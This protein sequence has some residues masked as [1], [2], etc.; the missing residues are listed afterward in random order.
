VFIIEHVIYIVCVWTLGNG[1]RLCV[2]L[3]IVEERFDFFSLLDDSQNSHFIHPASVQ[4]QH[5]ECRSDTVIWFDS[6]SLP[7]RSDASV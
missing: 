3:I 6:L 4:H 7:V 5:H 1:S 2:L